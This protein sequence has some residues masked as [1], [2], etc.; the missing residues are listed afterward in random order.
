[1][2]GDILYLL[3]WES[4]GP[5]V[6]T[7]YCT[8]VGTWVGGGARGACARIFNIRLGLNS[9]DPQECTPN[10]HDESAWLY[11]SHHYGNY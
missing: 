5:C 9:A 10:L 3:W 8:G 6:D 1:M 11:Q 4:T 7:H 2:A